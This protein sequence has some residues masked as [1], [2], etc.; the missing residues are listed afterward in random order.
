MPAPLFVDIGEALV[1]MGD[2]ELSEGMAF[3]E[4][5]TELAETTF[6]YWEWLTGRGI[7]R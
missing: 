2:G 5:T 1:M 3:L 4:R 7:W 6:R